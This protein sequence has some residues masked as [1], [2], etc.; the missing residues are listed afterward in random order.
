MN[1]Q[2]SGG[3]KDSR[4]D[5]TSRIQLPPDVGDCVKLFRLGG[6]VCN[7]GASALAPGFPASFYQGD[8]RRPGARL[9]RSGRPSKASRPA[10]ASRSIATGNSPPPGPYDLWLR[11]DDDGKG[12][13]SMTQCKDGND[14]ARL[15][16]NHL[17]GHP[18]ITKTISA[19][20]WSQTLQTLTLRR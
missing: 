11:A 3:S 1:V 17:H 16:T 15:G 6:V 4:P 14:L 9:I 8:P 12:T 19:G 2:G 7:R 18:L 5:A 20:S 10:S 13:R